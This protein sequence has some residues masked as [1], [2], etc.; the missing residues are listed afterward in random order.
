MAF[1]TT[2]YF[3]LLIASLSLVVYIFDAPEKILGS[4]ASV[5][6]EIDAKPYAVAHNATTTRYQKDGKLD[7]S[8]KAVRLE[9]YQIGDKDNQQEAFTLLER[10]QLVFYQANEE[11]WFIRSEKGKIDNTNQQ[12]E[13][14][15]KVLV[16]YTNLQN[17][18]AVITTE[19]LNIDTVN[20]FAETGEPVKINF[21][22]TAIEGTGMTA[23]F[24]SEKIK[25]LSNVR[26]T[27]DP[28]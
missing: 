4:D 22:T 19:K 7:Y 18:S 20:K 24:I 8:F 6:T 16:K 21:D 9:H 15:S 17:T 11:P 2:A 25:L 12:I 27:Y 28:N 14:W 26:G 23:D 5:A 13:L 1:K 10:P 3:I